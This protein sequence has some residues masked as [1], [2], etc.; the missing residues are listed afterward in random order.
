MLALLAACGGSGSAPARAAGVPGIRFV[1][2]ATTGTV[3]IR[4]DGARRPT[5][6]SVPPPEADPRE[7]RLELARR[8]PR[9]SGCRPAFAGRSGRRGEPWTRGETLSKP[10][11][12]G[13]RTERR[14][15]LE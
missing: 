3:L 12:P 1:Y 2:A 15:S 11:P 6:W 8:Y 9:A 7:A 13:E 10:V 4:W 5:V 14:R